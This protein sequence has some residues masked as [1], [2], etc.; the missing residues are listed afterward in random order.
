M[1]LRCNRL[2]KEQ[3][4]P[5][6]QNGKQGQSDK[7]NHRKFIIII[8]IISSSSCLSMYSALYTLLM[9]L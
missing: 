5:P 7:L 8:I 1:K 6:L 3:L 4:L 9:E 2:L